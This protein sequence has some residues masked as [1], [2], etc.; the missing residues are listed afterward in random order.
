MTSF[1]CKEGVLG[2]PCSILY[3]QRVNEHQYTLCLNLHHKKLRQKEGRWTFVYKS[4]YQAEMVASTEANSAKM[5]DFSL[6]K[7]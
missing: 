6:F 1:V 5:Q 3:R 7:G 2:G 4:L